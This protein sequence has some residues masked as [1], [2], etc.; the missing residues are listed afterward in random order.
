MRQGV[1]AFS[2]AVAVSIM[3]GS[4]LLAPS[5]GQAAVPFALTTPTEQTALTQRVNYVCRRGAHG[6]ECYYVLPPNRGPRY[7]RP[8]ANRSYQLPGFTYDDLKYNY[9]HWGGGDAPN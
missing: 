6:R 8:Y 7:S 3:L 9:H 2:T 4:M 5:R 1:I